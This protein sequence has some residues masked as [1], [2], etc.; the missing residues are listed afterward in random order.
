MS[1][2]EWIKLS[3][4]LFTDE[5]ISRLENMKNGKEI[6]LIW[7]RLLLLA[8]KQNNGGVFKN[9]S[10]GMFA[11]L[12][13]QPKPLINK[14][15]SAFV[16][17]GMVE[18]HEDDYVI[19]N[20]TKHQSEDRMS[21]IRQ[22]DRE[23]KK[24]KKSMENSMENSTETPSET[25]RN[26]LFKNKENKNKENTLLTESTKESTLTRKKYGRYENVFLTDEE[27]DSLQEEFPDYAVRLER[28]S[29]YMA[30][31]GKTYANHLA[32]IR[33]WAKQ[34]KQETVKSSSYDIDELERMI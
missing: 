11:S 1:K 16:E 20:W 2:I 7:I 30:S 12:L 9:F 17:H 22:K 3:V 24:K 31:S 21:Q 32:K 25:P 23:R 34:D 18:V 5:K 10:K 6:V 27:Y 19:C 8:G 14:A 29:E 28:L 13:S 15:L 33:E 4:D 26:P